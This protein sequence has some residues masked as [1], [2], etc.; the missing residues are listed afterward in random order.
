MTFERTDGRQFVKGCRKSVQGQWA[1]VTITA[2]ADC[3]RYPG[4]V[5]SDELLKLLMFTESTG[6]PC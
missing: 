4:E 6:H 3:S 2:F 1:S 5:H